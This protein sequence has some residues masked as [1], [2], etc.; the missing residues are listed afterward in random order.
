[1]L[2]KAE[3]A[4]TSCIVDACLVHRYDSLVEVL[5]AWG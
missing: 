1:M 2:R 5:E 4:C 3:A